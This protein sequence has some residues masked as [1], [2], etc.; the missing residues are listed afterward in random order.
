M[1]PSRLAVRPALESLT[2]E[3]RL[4]LPELKLDDARHRAWFDALMNDLGGAHAHGQK[5]DDS[6]EGPP[7]IA[8]RSGRRGR[9]G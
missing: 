8:V 9:G 7:G 4:Q 1:T 3:E 2:P 5:K 6:A